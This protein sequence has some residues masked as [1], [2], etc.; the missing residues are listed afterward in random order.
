MSNLGA[1]LALVVAGAFFIGALVAAIYF[2][3]SKR[4][5]GVPISFGSA[6]H[7]ALLGW[8]ATALLMLLMANI[9]PPLGLSPFLTV[10]AVLCLVFLCSA[11]VNTSLIR[12]ADGQSITFVDGMKLHALPMALLLAYVLSN[13]RVS[14]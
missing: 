10:P 5:I 6:F 14:A 2:F 4:V 7:A 13:Y 3:T 12:R 9:L 11:L 8:I 1:A